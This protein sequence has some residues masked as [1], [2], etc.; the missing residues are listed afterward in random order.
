[1]C[2]HAH[3]HVMLSSKDKKHVKKLAGI[4][5]PIYASVMLAAIAVVAVAGGTPPKG[6]LVAVNASSATR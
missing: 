3:F 6:E 2:H 4:M 1:M 5:I